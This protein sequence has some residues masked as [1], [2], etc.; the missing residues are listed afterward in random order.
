MN[1]HQDIKIFNWNIVELHEKLSGE[2]MWKEKKKIPK[3]EL[4]VGELIWYYKDHSSLILAQSRE[5]WK[6]FYIHC[7]KLS[8]N[9][10]NIYSQGKSL[11]ASTQFGCWKEINSILWEAA[12]QQ[13][14]QES[15]KELSTQILSLP[16]SMT[17]VA[18]K[19]RDPETMLKLLESTNITLESW[20]E[21]VQDYIKKHYIK[22]T[23]IK[24]IYAFKWEI[25]IWHI[26]DE[27]NF[28]TD[29]SSVKI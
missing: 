29:H 28:E 21:K 27:D 4:Y 8:Q 25:V 22:N 2:T 15:E 7:S 17:W 18:R 26:T 14:K 20:L 3:Y 5:E 13:A 24:D 1:E 11:V 10:V 19:I 23:D 16:I 12:Y 9:E 6:K